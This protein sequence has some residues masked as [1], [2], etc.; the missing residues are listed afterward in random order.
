MTTA[1]VPDR[2][3]LS[4]GEEAPYEIVA[5]QKREKPPMGM[6]ENWI[7]GTLF[8]WLDSF[9]R[10]RRLG[11]V[12]A[13]TLFV[14]DAASQLQRRPDLAFVSRT[15]WPRPPVRTNA[16]D[17]VPDLAVEVISP[18]NT[19]DDV[20]EKIEEYFAAGVRLVWVIYGE[21]QRIY[22]YQSPKA[23]S[24]L[25]THD[26]LDGG[27]TIPGFSLPLA[28]LFEDLSPERER[29]RAD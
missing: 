11:K 24:I 4:G 25:D 21:L 22:V 7:V 23:V 9:V 27:E 26:I 15:R 1:L 12:I 20:V 6:L 19:A 29:P 17:V 3:R 14:L 8:F 18:T 13:E 28:T 5:G 2:P 10:S 16:W